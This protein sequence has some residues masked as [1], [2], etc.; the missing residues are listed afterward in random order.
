MKVPINYYY[1]PKSEE[2]PLGKEYASTVGKW[3]IHEWVFHIKVKHRVLS[4]VGHIY[5]GHRV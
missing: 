1:P 4:I 3:K 2:N 5:F